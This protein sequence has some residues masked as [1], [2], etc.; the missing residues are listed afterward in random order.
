MFL[1]DFNMEPNYQHFSLIL[2]LLTLTCNFSSSQ[3]LS[4]PLIP[5]DT[6]LRYVRGVY[7]IPE[8]PNSI[9]VMYDGYFPIVW[10]L[11]MPSWDLETMKIQFWKDHNNCTQ[12]DAFSD[13]YV[14]PVM[15]HTNTLIEYFIGNMTIW[16]NLFLDDPQPT[17]F[18]GEFYMIYL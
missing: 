2:V 6:I 3:N 7:E 17:E 12:S 16:K 5:E 13:G 10:E 15:F 8:A 9:P 1:S 11:K 4:S 18:L 14:C